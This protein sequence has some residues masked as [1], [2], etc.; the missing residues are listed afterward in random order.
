MRKV[1]VRFAPS[2]TGPL[3]IGGVRTALYNYLFAKKHQGTFILRIE[4]TDQARYVPGAERYIIDSLNWCGLHPEEGPEQGGPFGPYRQ[5]ERKSI[6]LDH[7]HVLLEKGFAYYAFDTIEELEKMRGGAHDHA[8]YDASTRMAMRNSLAIGIEESKK[9]I[10]KGTSYVVRLLVPEDQ[11]ITFVDRIRGEVTFD[12]KELDDRVILKADG[13]PTYHLA[14]VVDDYCMKITHVIRGE[15]WLSSTAHH[16]LLYEAFGWQDSMPEFAH[17]PLILKPNGKGKLSKRDGQ[18]FGFPVF[19]LPWL[20]DDPDESFEGFK[21]VGFHP[22]ALL[23]FLAFLGWSP[24]TEQE[25]FSLDELIEAFTIEHIGKSGARFDYDKALWYNSQY[26]SNLTHEELKAAVLPFVQN[27][28]YSFN[29]DGLSA[30]C[31]LMQDRIKT[32]SEFLVESKYFFEPATQFD[33]L[34]VSKKWN[35]QTREA[36]LDII[37][38]VQTLP[39]FESNL[40]KEVISTSIS[41]CKLKFGDMLPLLR[42][43][44]TGEAKGADIFKI[45]EILGKE[46]SLKRLRQSFTEFEYLKNKPSSSAHPG[47]PSI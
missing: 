3:H 22:A 21:S 37:E 19:P 47:N 8:K 15:E 39:Q 12:T 34:T 18:K 5:S 2:P 40:I 38:K 41:D 33:E 42:I 7:V 23:N 24:G 25:I 4:D 36:Y 35:T 43:G 9:L 44:L 26:I 27:A 1:R 32:Y 45:M 29:D 13:L 16:V 28:G 20:D 17:L 10:E 31:E 6:Y 14:N 11:K 46:E 30:I